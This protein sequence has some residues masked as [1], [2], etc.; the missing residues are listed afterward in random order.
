MIWIRLLWPTNILRFMFLLSASEPVLLLVFSLLCTLF[1]GENFYR[2]F[3]EL[4]DGCIFDGM[5][6]QVGYFCGMSHLLVKEAEA[7]LSGMLA[8]APLE[9]GILESLM[10]RVNLS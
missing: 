8:C 6:G 2:G 7:Y 5:C 1:D 3:L 9:K 4:R 10:F